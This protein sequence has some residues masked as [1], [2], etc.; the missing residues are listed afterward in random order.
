MLIEKFESFKIIIKNSSHIYEK[1][2]IIFHDNRF[3]IFHNNK[4]IIFYN[5]HMIKNLLHVML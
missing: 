2:L 1:K 4:F 3:I 5:S